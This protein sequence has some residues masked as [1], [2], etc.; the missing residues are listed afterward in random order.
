MSFE[1][2]DVTASLF[3]IGL[4]YDCNDFLTI[5]SLVSKVICLFSMDSEGRLV[6][7]GHFRLGNALQLFYLKLLFYLLSFYVVNGI[8][9]YYKYSF[10][11]GIEMSTPLFDLISE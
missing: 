9:G 5:F 11:V 3:E 1:N 7:V 8:I 6:L 10:I 4:L 2:R